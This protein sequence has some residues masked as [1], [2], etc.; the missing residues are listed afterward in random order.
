MKL[1]RTIFTL[2]CHTFM[3]YSVSSRYF[4]PSASK[5]E[6]SYSF[7]AMHLNCTEYEDLNLG[8]GTFLFHNMDAVSHFSTC[9][10]DFDSLKRYASL[11]IG[12]T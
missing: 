11:P 2:S 9:A 6:M 10:L 4:S 7:L 8:D 5:H 12:S 1:Y 3:S